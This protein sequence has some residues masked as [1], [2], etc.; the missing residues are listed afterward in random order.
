M[1]TNGRLTKG[2]AQKA[3]SCSLSRPVCVP[4]VS[5]RSA[6]RGARNNVYQKT[7][8]HFGFKS[9]QVHIRST[10]SVQ[11]KSA[12]SNPI[13]W[14]VEWFFA[15]WIWMLLSYPP[16]A[17]LSYLPR[18]ILAE[19][20]WML[21]AERFW[22]LLSERSPLNNAI[23]CSAVTSVLT[24]RGN[25]QSYFHLGAFDPPDSFRTS[26][27][28]C[29]ESDAVSRSE[30][31]VP[32][33]T[34][35]DISRQRSSDCDRPIMSNSLRSA[36]YDQQVTISGL[37]SVGYDRQVMIGSL[38]YAQFM[39]GLKIHRSNAN[40]ITHLCCTHHKDSNGALATA[41][42]PDDIQTHSDSFRCSKYLQS[43][44]A[45]SQFLL[46]SFSVLHFS[47][48]EMLLNNTSNATQWAI[49]EKS[50]SVS[51]CQ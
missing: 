45:F 9:F 31:S 43:N 40:I 36:D 15:E 38:R 27:V 12:G 39:F 11:L 24:Y 25:W 3:Y 18:A 50:R 1:L 6:W 8:E 5:N 32:S 41:G 33:R 30:S 34:S 19:R 16:W 44:S 13:V 21:L 49:L 2:K 10:N 14:F 4:P 42:R 23:D 37:Q 47:N 20:F 28:E 29:F 48:G 51:L 46:S 26:P 7:I 35:F 22:M 17:I